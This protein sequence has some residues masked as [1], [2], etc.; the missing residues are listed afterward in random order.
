MH[1]EPDAGFHRDAVRCVARQGDGG[2]K[3]L[4]DQVGATVLIDKLEDRIIDPLLILIGGEFVSKDAAALVQPQSKQVPCC[5]CHITS[6]WSPF[7]AF[8]ETVTGCKDNALYT[9]LESL[10]FTVPQD[11]TRGHTC[12]RVV[13]DRQAAC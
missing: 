2:S 6:V 9:A 5:R 12:D 4:R 13:L 8:A 11:T 1:C 10:D 3:H 7:S